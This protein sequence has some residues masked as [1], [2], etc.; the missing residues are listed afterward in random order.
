MNTGLFFYIVKC[1]LAK[2]NAPGLYS[3]VTSS[4]G[5]K[6]KIRVSLILIVIFCFTVSGSDARQPIEKKIDSWLVLG[7]APVTVLENRVYPDL[8]SRA[9]HDYIDT[10]SV[11]PEPGKKAQWLPGTYLHWE[12]TGSLRFRPEADSI[13][14]FAVYPDALRR[15]KAAL[16]LRGIS[17]SFVDVYFDG[18]KVKKDFDREK[19][20]VRAE[21]DMLN[22][23][24][25]L[26]LKILVPGGR[27]FS[28]NASL[29]YGE[30]NRIDD[31]SFS[32]V[33]Y[34][35][36]N[37]RNIL[38]M[39]GV[40]NV[41]LS[42][43]G[44]MAFVSLRRMEQ[45]GRSVA[46]NEVLNMNSGETVY[47]TEGAGSLSGVR[48]LKDSVSITYTASEKEITS[49]FRLNVKTGAR[50]LVAG[51]LRDFSDYRWSPDNTFIIYTKSLK[52]DTGTGFKYINEIPQ[53]T[54]FPVSRG[55]VFLYYP[56]G[57]ITHKVASE[58]DD[59][60]DVIISPDS[61][62]VLLVKSI[63]DNE[64]RPYY[65]TILFLLDME[66]LSLS[67]IL[68]SNHANP[69]MWSPD[70]G[71]IVM[72]GGPS[73]FG[74]AG[75]VLPGN[76]IPNDYDNQVYIFDPGSG[77]AEPITKN[78]DPSV[79]R[80]HWSGGT[81][82]MSVTEGSYENL[83]RYDL[84]GK[85]FLKIN[86]PVDVTGDVW[87]SQNGAAAVFWGSGSV[88]PH[89]LYK[90]DLRSGRTAV[91]RDYN[92]EDFKYVRFG[93]VVNW[94]HDNGEGKVIS[95]RVYHPA[96]FDSEKK[97][98]CI[99]YYYGGT[100]PVERS[101]GGRY[102]FNWYAANGYVVY[103]LQPSGTVGYGQA[104]SAV[105][106]NDW[107]KTTSEEVIAAT[108]AVL[109]AH[110]DVDPARVGAMGASYGGF[111]TQYLATQT[112]IFSAFISHAGISSLSSYW[113]VGDWGYSYSGV[114]TAG[115]F[116]WNRK[117]IYVDRSPLFM[118]DKINTPLLLLHGDRDNNVPP[119]E[120]YQMYA[121][122]KLL[123]KEVAL[124]T[125]DDQAHWIL[126]YSKRVRW[127]KTIIAWFDKWLKKDPFY[128]DTLYGKYFDTKKK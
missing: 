128:W 79:N 23:K 34:R 84:R 22:A 67:K 69:V 17:D 66:S 72:T 21:L 15:L 58:D 77:N 83:Y 111:L 47:T 46:W 121:A 10:T 3:R 7:P 65:K 27:E 14:Y 117:D 30:N 41:R 122:L 25:I 88:L 11:V 8:K 28:L 109:G 114:A 87:F 76:V 74:G 36:V 39:T 97:Y 50:S 94:D 70:S 125:I 116:P 93:K 56:A 108:R 104:F 53:R 98:P 110:P 35:R 124:I 48:W 82:Y 52:Q 95:G 44:R 45:D 71:K 126:N 68:E 18:R 103:V 42:P 89:K 59:F 63:S 106:V 13:Y 12:N 105:H 78:F 9:N 43:D 57:G 19:G 81:I 127:M 102:P 80:L 75:S 119:G 120:S 73:A 26:L 49:I 5:G 90:T 6:M 24:H 86:T 2:W 113:G 96:D 1:V 60:N 55:S 62:K 54:K 85:R 92:R 99:V 20:T 101:F 31:V 16:V 107:G 61:R 118:A 123:G 64:N 29:E 33:L 91:L 4:G 40:S 100:S 38:N 32:T 37:F 112:D 51:N 115:S